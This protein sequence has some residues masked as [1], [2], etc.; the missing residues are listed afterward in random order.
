[1]SFEN[2]I[3]FSLKLLPLINGA[4]ESTVFSPASILNGLSIILA[5]AKGETANQIAQVLGKGKTADEIIKYVSESIKDCKSSTNELVKIEI[6]N[7]IFISKKKELIPEFSKFLQQSFDS[8]AKS[9]DFE[10][11]EASVKEIN[12]FADKSTNGKIKEVVTKGD[13][14]GD[15]SAVLIN[16]V[17]FKGQ[18]EQF[19]HGRRSGIFKSNPPR[20]ISFINATIWHSWYYNNG[21]DWESA[22]IPYKNKDVWMY[23]IMPKEEGGLGKL[24]EKM[25]AKLF[26]ACTKPRIDYLSLTMPAFEITKDIDLKEKLFEMGIQQVFSDASDLGNMIEEPTK[27]AKIFHK[28]TINV[29]EYGTEASGVTTS[30]MIP[31]CMPTVL[32]IDKPFLYFITVNEKYEETKENGDNVEVKKL[33]KPKKVLFAGTFC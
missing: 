5:A 26:E 21:T 16:A 25:D 8:D 29:D 9:I 13:F 32:R 17:Y 7:R 15:I 1:M 10:K 12:D 23:I 11:V 22:G 20:E 19:F 33:T 30:V 27:V 3:E 28:A 2:D 18:W 6:A 31:M 14:Q 24:I 4:S